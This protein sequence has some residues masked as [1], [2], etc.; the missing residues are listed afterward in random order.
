VQAALQAHDVGAAHAA[1]AA[2]LIAIAEG[3]DDD[4]DNGEQRQ[5]P[6]QQQA[7]PVTFGN[8]LREK[9][10]QQLKVCMHC[11]GMSIYCM[12]GHVQ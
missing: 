12:R 11:T 2:A 7:A 4:A 5:P 9:A 3:G 1:A 8:L 6:P 10:G